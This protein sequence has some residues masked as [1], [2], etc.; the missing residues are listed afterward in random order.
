M[1]SG[2]DTPFTGE[3]QTA[4]FKGGIGKGIHLKDMEPF[5]DFVLNHLVEQA[6]LF[7]GEALLP[8]NGK[9][10]VIIT[11]HGPG[12]A[13]VPILAL[14]GKHYVDFGYGNLIGGMVPHKAVF[15]IP[16]LKAYYKKVLGAPTSVGSV[17]ELVLL[18]K[19]RQIQVTGTAPEGANS[20][21]SFREY[22]G[23]F[24]SRGMIAAA[25]RAEANLVLVTHQGAETWNRRLRMPLGLSLPN[26]FGLRGVNLTLPPYRKLDHYVALCKAYKPSMKAW[27]FKTRSS[28][29]CRLLLHVE[30]ETIRAEMNLMTDKAKTLLAGRRLQKLVERGPGT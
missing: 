27:D 18:L 8:Q 21:L 3:S 22:V 13:W 4:S 9:P 23:P 30:A 5:Y 16:G 29:E 17:D 6:E 14:L 7:N 12:L 2:P 20:F 15:L 1:K 26:S 10:V 25:I 24:R 19:N 28:R 11:S